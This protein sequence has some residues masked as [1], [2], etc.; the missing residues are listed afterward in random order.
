MQLSGEGRWLGRAVWAFMRAT[1][2]FEMV[3]YR[4][5]DG[6]DRLESDRGG[7]V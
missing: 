6:G 5:R 2:R 1:W 3:A 4:F 7:V